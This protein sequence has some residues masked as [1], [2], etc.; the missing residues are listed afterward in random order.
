MV[1]IKVHESSKL[2]ILTC[3]DFKKSHSFIR[4]ID[5]GRGKSL[6]L[7][8]D[9]EQTN[10]SYFRS[11][12]GRV[13]IDRV[14]PEMMEVKA[15]ESSELDENSPCDDD[16]DV[17]DDVDLSVIESDYEC[18]AEKHVTATQQLDESHHRFSTYNEVMFDR[19]TH[20]LSTAR[21]R[22]E[23][24]SRKIRSVEV[25]GTAK[26]KDALKQI[27]FRHSEEILCTS[28]MACNSRHEE[29]RVVSEEVKI[30]PYTQARRKTFK[31]GRKIDSL[32]SEF[33]R[34]QSSER[35][36]DAEL[37]SEMVD[38]LASYENLYQST[39]TK[40]DDD[41]QE[42]Q[43]DAVFN[44][45]DNLDLYKV[46]IEY[47]ERV[48]SNLQREYKSDGD[49]LDEVGK[50]LVVHEVP[51]KNHSVDFDEKLTSICSDRDD[52]DVPEQP[53]HQP[54]EAPDTPVRSCLVTRRESNKRT[55]S[56]SDKDHL[57]VSQPDIKSNLLSTQN[58][59][60]SSEKSFGKL[61]K[62]NRFLRVKRFSSSALLAKS[63]G[64]ESDANMTESTRCSESNSSKTSLASPK[65]L[66]SKKKSTK[67]RRFSFFGKSHSNNDISLNLKSLA[68]KLSLL[69]K[70]NF[71]LSK[72]LSNLRLNSV[73]TYNMKGTST[74]YRSDIIT[75]KGS[76][77]SPLSEAFYNATGSY[78]LTP[79]EL[80]EKFCS[81][82][83]TGL[84]KNEVLNDDELYPPHESQIIPK[85]AIKKTS[86]LYKQ[87]SE[88]RFGNQKECANDQYYHPNKY[89]YED[90]IFE[91]DE[92]CVDVYMQPMHTTNRRRSSFE[93]NREYHRDH[94]DNFY[95]HDE[96]L[97]EVSRTYKSNE[98]ISAID[99]TD[100]EEEAMN[101]NE[102]EFDDGEI[103]EVHQPNDE[104]TEYL[105]SKYVEQAAHID[106]EVNESLMKELSADQLLSRSSETLNSISN[107]EGL[108][109]T[110]KQ[111]NFDS[112]CASN[113]SL[114]LNSEILDENH[115]TPK[116]P[117]VKIRT[118]TM[119]EID[120]FTLTPD[121]SILS[122]KLL[123]AQNTEIRLCDISS[124]YSLECEELE[125]DDEAQTDK[126]FGELVNRDFDR[127]F[128]K[129]RND[130]DTDLT[131]TPSAATV[132]TA[133][134]ISSRSVDKL[135]VLPLEFQPSPLQH[136][137]EILGI[138]APSAQE[139]T[140]SI[141][142]SNLQG[143]SSSSSAAEKL[144]L[145][146]L[147]AKR[148]LSTGAIN[149]KKHSNVLLCNHL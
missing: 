105:M 37:V 66:K 43:S 34:E 110:L 58:N 117:P 90:N 20:E 112:S 96:D 87:N 22:S 21:A 91:E 104:N 137:D 57:T 77:L 48:K 95:E 70:S 2:C 36:Q 80:F 108:L 44:S 65:S 31:R 89:F 50:D 71:D 114:S 72:N 45:E 8:P 52:E 141:T 116:P 145:E 33:S 27:K 54:I 51:W 41:E 24:S 121:G 138:A 120:D 39:S 85:G 147:K 7:T 92:G 10:H 101:E 30:N 82:E 84:Y 143:S 11:N 5:F 26:V 53:Q 115:A 74:E 97:L 79:M 16:D 122:N 88:P 140:K 64:V 98:D 148:S 75:N 129:V 128:I 94:L 60:T 109:D 61:R 125:E 55:K 100:E 38:E 123:Q 32:T 35:Q 131:A 12:K 4:F 15:G 130:S 107:T 126:Q 119:S 136:D 139:L 113:I 25:V 142:S 132:L 149:K 127:M 133:I 86:L 40:L 144:E 56:E 63:V 3:I 68:S 42:V 78:Q 47:M 17:E 76:C 102:N 13:V 93:R 118:M 46:E 6:P 28:S 103:V 9:S 62:I 67:K 73:G 111:M 81:T 1:S 49:S 134:K 59:S 106:S 135:D 83:F 146:K 14:I 99:E 23:L 29:Q 124:Q 69:S 18:A 19:V